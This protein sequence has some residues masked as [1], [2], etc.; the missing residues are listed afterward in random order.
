[1]AWQ[2]SHCALYISTGN[3]QFFTASYLTYHRHKEYTVNGQGTSTNFMIKNYYEINYNHCITS[4]SGWDGL[5][6]W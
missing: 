5:G 4:M 2:S 6:Y 3:E 1:M